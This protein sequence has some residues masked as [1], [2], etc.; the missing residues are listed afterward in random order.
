MPEFGKKE[1][2]ELAY[3]ERKFFE[4]LHA[5][6]LSMYEENMPPEVVERMNHLAEQMDRETDVIERLEMEMSDE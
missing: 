5:D 4:L 3:E 2:L 1:K 6:L